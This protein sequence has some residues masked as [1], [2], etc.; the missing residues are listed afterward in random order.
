MIEH[1]SPHRDFTRRAIAELSKGASDEEFMDY[2]KRYYRLALLTAEETK[3]LNKINRS[4]VT[5][6]RLAPS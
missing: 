1:V 4:Q 2:V 5:A 6:N 3:R